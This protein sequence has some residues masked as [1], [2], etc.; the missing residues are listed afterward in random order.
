MIEQL[1]QRATVSSWCWLLVRILHLKFANDRRNNRGACCGTGVG[2]VF[3][4]RCASNVQMVILALVVLFAAFC[5]GIAIG[6]LFTIWFFLFGLES[7][8]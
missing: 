6:L 5:I 4:L 8:E 3:L 1:L 7:G 2:A